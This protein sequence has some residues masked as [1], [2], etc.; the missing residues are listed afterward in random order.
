MIG[1]TS[2][3][4]V[5]VGLDR[6]DDAVAALHWAARE[7]SRGGELITVHAFAPCPGRQGRHRS[8]SERLRAKMRDAERRDVENLIAGVRS[9]VELPS[10]RRHYVVDLP[11]RALTTLG[12]NADLLVIGAHGDGTAEPHRLG[13]TPRT[14]R[15]S[16]PCP[17]VIVS[18]LYGVSVPERAFAVA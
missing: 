12:A 3:Y 1:S 18:A 11:G 17:V 9:I 2:S 5:I 7:A 10:V 6:S 16:A 13:S 8:G 4:R 15:Q 14:C